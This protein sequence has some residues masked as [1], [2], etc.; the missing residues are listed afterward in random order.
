MVAMT[1]AVVI[2]RRHIFIGHFNSLFP[3]FAIPVIVL[4]IITAQVE[5]RA[6]IRRNDTDLTVSALDHHTAAGCVRH[7]KMT[8]LPVFRYEIPLPC[9]LICMRYPWTAQPALGFFFL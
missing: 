6:D 9:N 4:H 1:E 8:V 7:H 2:I 3:E 5:I